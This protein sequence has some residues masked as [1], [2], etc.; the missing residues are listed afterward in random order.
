MSTLRTAATDYLTVR[1]AL[2]F[3][4]YDAGLLLG[5][6]IDFLEARHTN[7]ITTELAVQWA[8]APRDTL[9]AWHARRLSVVRGFARWRQP[10]DPATEV[11]PLGLLRARSQRTTPYLYSAEEV[12]ALMNAAGT[13]RSPLKA[14]TMQTFIGLVFATGIRRGEALG[15]DRADLDPVAGVLTIRTAKRDKTRRL[16]LHPSTVA[17]LTDYQQRRD[18]L[19][20]HPR[21]DA[22]LVSTTGARLS[23]P[24]V[25]QTFRVLLRQTGIESPAPARRPHIHD[26]RH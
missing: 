6:F 5:Q 16:P 24:T 25:S 14:A 3:K 12:A 8:T 21:T 2:G 19:C 10:S 1:R 13:L 26:A 20:R 15:L 23:A 7:T 17:A 9:P 18:R 11:P 22:L 4:L